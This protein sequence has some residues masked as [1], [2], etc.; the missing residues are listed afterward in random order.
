MII[1]RKNYDAKMT[2]LSAQNMSLSEQFLEM[3]EKLGVRKLNIASV[4]NSISAGY[5]KCDKILP[6][7][8][9]S[10]IYKLSSDINY[11]SYARIRRNEDINI[12]RWYN[13]NISHKDINALNI[14]DIAEKQHA[15]I[16][17]HW[18]DQTLKNYEDIA[19]KN[20]IGFRDFNLLDDNIIIYNG[21]TGEF[22]DIIRKGNSSDKIRILKSFKRDMENA[23]LILTQMYLDNPNTQ[24][25]VC[26][27]PNIQGTGI[28]SL[29][30]KYIKEIC[31]Q[32][33]N[34]IYLPG[35][36]RNSLFYLEG[37]KE[38]DIHYSQPEYLDLWN[39]ITKSMI[40]NYVPKK[41]IITVLE[42]LKKYSASIELE[43]TASKGSEEVISQIIGEEYEKH[44]DLFIRNGQSIDSCID[45]I[46][47]YYDRNYLSTFPCTPREKVLTKFQDFKKKSSSIQ[48]IEIPSEV[49]HNK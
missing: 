42:R 2:T 38:F 24:V 25:Y 32:I 46:T 9:R 41:F 19:S 40:E 4:G 23:K 18:D 47:K 3:L 17:K 48:T 12:L 16:Q 33:P 31:A 30:D 49:R 7:L 10:N 11:F 26:G 45:E 6:F 20:N 22:T 44:I 27:L 5:S 39:N 14:D 28:I 29:L 34:T 35:T 37:Q 13:S 43:S 21:F 8:M 15:Y 36:I 1:T